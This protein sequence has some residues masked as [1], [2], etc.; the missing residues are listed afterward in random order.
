MNSGIDIRFRHR[1]M[2]FPLV[3]PRVFLIYTIPTQEKCFATDA[4]IF[5][6]QGVIILNCYLKVSICKNCITTLKSPF[7]NLDPLVRT[8]LRC[9]SASINCV[10]YFVHTFNKFFLYQNVY[11]YIKSW[12][13]I[14]KSLNK[15]KYI[16]CNNN[17]NQNSHNIPHALLWI[18]KQF[19]AQ[20][21]LYNFTT[22]HLLFFPQKFEWFKTL[23]NDLK[24]S[25][26][27]YKRNYCHI[28]MTI[29]DI[30]IDLRR[31]LQLRVQLRTLLQSFFHKSFNR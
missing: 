24:L 9:V 31:N 5:L 6:S 4:N 20:S 17:F 19:S 28:T 1:A 22:D 27:F 12:P 21:L 2:R 14:Q 30:E 11:T 8:R 16:A 15:I 26:P 13:N 29:S 23:P 18:R 7:L 10:Y 25:H 3:E